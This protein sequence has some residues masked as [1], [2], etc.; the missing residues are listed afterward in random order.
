M[1]TNYVQ[2]QQPVPLKQ[3]NL[4][5]GYMIRLASL[6]L[7][8]C[9]C[10]NK[11]SLCVKCYGDL[12]ENYI[13]KSINIVILGCIF[14]EINLNLMEDLYRMFCMK[15]SVFLRNIFCKTNMGSFIQYVRKIFRKTNNSYPLIRTRTCAYH[16]LSNHCRTQSI[17]WDTIYSCHC[18]LRL[19]T[20]RPP[21]WGL[22]GRKFLILI[23]LDRWKMHFRENNFIENYFCY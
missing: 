5:P 12:S 1:S 13:L 6:Q 7:S 19:V 10:M 23:T 21:L 20:P 14:Y 15:L 22:S 17:F 11:L 9:L 18:K 2:S 4:N 3:G 8:C 16:G